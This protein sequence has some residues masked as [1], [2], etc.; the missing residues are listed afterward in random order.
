MSRLK[1]NYH[2][3]DLRNSLLKAAIDLVER[4]GIAKLSMRE[5]ARQAGVSPGAP[6][7]HFKNKDALLTALAEVS[8][9][10]LDELSTQAKEGC[11]T[12]QARLEAIGVAY[13]RYATDHPA[14][15]QLMFSYARDDVPSDLSDAPVYRVLASVVREFDLTGE[16]HIAATMAAWS[17]VH[18]LAVLVIDGPLRHLAHQPEQVMQL[19]KAVTAHL[20]L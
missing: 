5:V 1:P 12:P 13:I 15:F 16:A 11:K 10:T 3:G 20:R 4:N 8:L 9:W 17:L 2:H 18:G 7:H 19:A 6:Y 14:L